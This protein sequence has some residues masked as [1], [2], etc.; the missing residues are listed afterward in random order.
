VRVGIEH[1]RGSR[2]IRS[3]SFYRITA[4]YVILAVMV[5][6]LLLTL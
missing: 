4:V 3:I 6:A 1:L 5:I 2:L